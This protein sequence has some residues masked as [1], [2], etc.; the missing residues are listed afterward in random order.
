MRKNMHR[1]RRSIK[2]RGVRLKDGGRENHVLGFVT[3]RMPRCYS[4]NPASLSSSL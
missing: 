3:I 2:E 1:I 4:L